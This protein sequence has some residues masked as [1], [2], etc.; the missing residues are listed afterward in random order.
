M[1]KLATLTIG[2][3]FAAGSAFAQSN[4]ASVSQSGDQNEATIQQ[5]YQA[6]G[7][8]DINEAFVIQSGNENVVGALKQQGAGNWYEIVQTGDRNIVER[9]PNQGSSHGGS[10]DGYISII[11]TGDENKVWDADQT[12]SGNSLI[13]NQDGSDI[14][15]VESQV[16]PEGGIGNSITISQFGGENAVGEYSAKGSGAYQEGEANSMDITQE[17]GAKAGV[18]SVYV[19]GATEQFFKGLEEGGQGLIQLGDDNALSINQDG[20]SIVEFVIQ[21]GNLNNSVVEQTGDFH[22]ATV[23]Q[24]GNNNSGT[25]NQSSF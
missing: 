22:N 9:Y 11:Q 15:N 23:S 2:F 13:I 7:S 4:E 18:A 25:I 17:G 16:S 14:V 21:K 3:F 24:I 8:G 6:G 1:K 10:Y 5:V 19:S 12:G 20:A